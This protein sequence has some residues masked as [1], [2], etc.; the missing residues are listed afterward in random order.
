MG[1]VR[2]A[3]VQVTGTQPG[4]RGPSA[5]VSQAAGDITVHLLL[6]CLFYPLCTKTLHF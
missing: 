6:A 4:E 1:Q 5:W 2:M 3:Q